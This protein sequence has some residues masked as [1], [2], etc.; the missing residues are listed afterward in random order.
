MKI[1][2]REVA[3][4][5]VGALASF[6]LASIQMS[7]WPSGLKPNLDFPYLYAGDGLF[8]LWLIQRLADG[9]IFNNPRQGFPFGAPAFDFPGSD[10][11]NL[12]VS[13]LLAEGLGTYFAAFNVYFLL[14]FSVTFAAAFMVLRRIG[15]GRVGSC[16]SALLFAFLPYHFARM[17]M[18]HT[19]YTW[20]FVV[21]VYFYCGVKVF[22][23]AA[24]GTMRGAWRCILAL[25][26]ASC[27]GVYF[28]LFGVFTIMVCGVAGLVKAGSTRPLGYAL[29]F[30]AAIAA[31]VVL[32]VA[33]NL[34]Y[35]AAHGK[36][37]EVA[38][39]EARET[40]TYSL[41]L[42]HMVIPYSHH[43]IQAL[44][45]YARHYNTNFPLSN[46]TSTLGA[47][48]LLGLLLLAL[49]LVRSTTGTAF[50]PRMGLLVLL[51]GA[52]LLVVSV[53]GLNVLFA[54]LVS[55]M[56][57]GWDRFSVFVAFYA[58][59]ALALAVD[60]LARRRGVW[61]VALI[62]LTVLALLEQTTSPR[63]YKAMTSQGRFIQERA[64]VQAIEARLPEGA[65]IYQLP[66]I[67][68]PEVSDLHGLGTY[69]SL[70]GFLNS[71]ALRWSFGG[72]MGREADLFY[73]A[74]SKKPMAEQV[75]TVRRM[76]FSGIYLDRRGYADRGEAAVAELT[77]LV[78]PPVLSQANGSALFFQVS[79]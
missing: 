62:V 68:F 70:T 73:R 59:A 3:C 34:A 8:Q 6:L 64:F 21:P 27:F 23:T 48:G 25:L 12:L 40:E 4:I 14:G 60:H 17:M 43:R 58:L 79:K 51:T 67:H 32:N 29:V 36:N 74:L 7:G 30:S 49:A 5:A 1:N 33:P 31:G 54:T 41:K 53:G 16:A 72:M 69:D 71:K 24:A 22:E 57:R 11:G 19:F 75:E 47:A 76:G 2:C 37:P 65:A 35:R 20:Y 38:Q 61:V 10:A 18:G 39:R 46:T 28:A 15:V 55:P 50:D 9:W 66:Y 78:G 52:S 44:R 56:I 42:M 63:T 13:K 26:V 77:S 45:D